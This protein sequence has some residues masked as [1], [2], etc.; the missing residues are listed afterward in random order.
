MAGAFAIYQSLTGDLEGWFEPRAVPPTPEQ[1]IR[2]LVLPFRG[3][4]ELVIVRA[5][6]RGESEFA[7]HGVEPGETVFEAARREAWEEVGAELGA[8]HFLG[9]TRCSLSVVAASVL[10]NFR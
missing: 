3:T 4:Q 8:L 7:G 10:P 2:V 6:S 9:L 1:V 5:R